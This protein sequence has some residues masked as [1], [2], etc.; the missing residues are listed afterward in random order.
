MDDSLYVKQM[1]GS[2]GEPTVA[3]EVPVQEG[4]ALVGDALR[5][6]AEAV[7]AGDAWGAVEALWASPVLDGMVRRVRQRWPWLPD[8]DVDRAVGEA[9]DA[10]HAAVLAGETIR[11]P[12]HWL[13]Q[14]VRNRAAQIMRDR[15]R[16]VPQDPGRLGAIAHGGEPELVL[17]AEERRARA[18]AHARRLLPR[19]GQANVQAVMEVVIDAVDRQVPSLSVV[20]IAQALG[21]SQ[22]SVKV[23][24]WRGFDRLA[25]LAAEEGLAA[26]DFRLEH[27]DDEDQEEE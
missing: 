10:F 27:A 9:F 1:P 23:W 6:A 19:L 13:A 2:P 21:Q 25:R 16:E 24:Y 17:A 14:T 3:D 20:D 5:A 12:V 4:S 26:E 8:D 11:H 22:Q 7:A 18:V 15:A